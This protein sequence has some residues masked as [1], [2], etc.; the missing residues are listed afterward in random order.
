M[1]DQPSTVL[2]GQFTDDNAERI[3]ARLEDAGITWWVKSGGRFTRALFAGEW[4]TRVFVDE[5]R[6]EQARTIAARIVEP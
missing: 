5:A 6:L 3:V 4:G 2:L 1:S